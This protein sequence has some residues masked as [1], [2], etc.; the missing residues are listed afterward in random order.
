MAGTNDAPVEVP[1][2]ASTGDT[3][4]SLTV[5]YKT[6][7]KVSLTS[8][9]INIGKDF[10]ITDNWNPSTNTISLK[11]TNSIPV[12]GK[13]NIAW[14]LTGT[15][16]HKKT[17]KSPD[18]YQNAQCTLVAGLTAST[19]TN[20]IPWGTSLRGNIQ[21]TSAT[22]VSDLAGKLE[23]SQEQII[24]INGAISSQE[25]FDV[26]NLS[27]I[28]AG[29]Y[30]LT[31]GEFPANLNISKP[32]QWTTTGSITYK[33]PTLWQSVHVD[34]GLGFAF[35]GTP[36]AIDSA[37]ITVSSTANW[38][39]SQ[40]ITVIGGITFTQTSPDVGPGGIRS[41]FTLSTWQF[42]LGLTLKF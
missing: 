13:G 33:L 18:N 5:T 30:T 23:L 14:N 2:P 39:I 11:A 22:A 24:G 1:N 8:L 27:S 40:T 31:L 25:L 19:P 34:S 41:Y 9:G 15:D 16:T 37:N 21:T 7:P 28:L 3:N 20:S 38:D 29:Q 36:S 26:K 12:L 6:T 32:W 42:E 17:G 4:N 10:L 35:A